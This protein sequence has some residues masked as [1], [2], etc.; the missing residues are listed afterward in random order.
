MKR[1]S[2]LRVKNATG[3]RAGALVQTSE[4]EAISRARQ[5]FAT[6]DAY[7]DPGYWYI[8][9]QVGGLVATVRILNTKSSGKDVGFYCWAI[10]LL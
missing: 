3:V 4:N 1:G 6:I 5:A 9:Y 8:F 10:Q 7:E 2:L